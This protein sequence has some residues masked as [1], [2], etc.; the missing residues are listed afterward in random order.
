[1][2]AN[3]QI[4][5]LNPTSF[6]IIIPPV[7]G[8]GEKQA[9][10]GLF[11]FRIDISGKE[12]LVEWPLNFRSAELSPNTSKEFRW[13]ESISISGKNLMSEAVKIRYKNPEGNYFDIPVDFFSSTEIRF[14]PKAPIAEQSPSLEI[15]VRGKQYLLENAFLLKSA[16]I[17]PGQNFTILNGEVFTIS[18]QNFNPDFYRINELASDL[19]GLNFEIYETKTDRITFRIIPRDDFFLPRS[20]V[21]YANNF[22]LKSENSASISFGDITLPF[23]STSEQIGD[24]EYVLGSVAVG[25]KGYFFSPQKI[26][27]FD[28][29]KRNS[30]L[31]YNFP[32][33]YQLTVFPFVVPAP[34]GRI[35]VGGQGII[36]GSSNELPII[37]ELDPATKQVKVLP[38][39]PS[40]LVYTISAYTTEKYLYCDG[41]F[42]HD[43][44]LG[45]TEKSERWRY[46]I[47][48]GKW[49]K[50]PTPSFSYQGQ[51]VRLLGFRYKNRL[52]RFGYS[53]ENFMA[54]LFRFDPVTESWENLAEFENLQNL[55]AGQVPVV[56]NKAYFESNSGLVEMN[57]DDYSIRRIN[58]GGNSHSLVNLM[59]IGDKIYST[60]F[61][62]VY[63]TDPAYFKY[64]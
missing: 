36:D 43:P 38:Q 62:R 7:F 5:D 63:E 15:T 55:T 33:K 40:N 37:F 1:M 50:L 59:V 21:I 49:E 51:I 35:Y 45:Y 16:E 44:S 13:D 56:G 3:A 48:E 11:D 18:G 23:L 22:G 19:P 30:T 61:N 12:L 28:P 57:L 58:L 53:P 8:F 47:V 31:V 32:E 4:I 24:F 10:Q 27:E 25:D 6:K 60:S 20:L 42:A 29:R 54:S 52:F 39:H 9:N 46:S 64:D 2:G 34:N 26:V 17:D 14:K 41:G